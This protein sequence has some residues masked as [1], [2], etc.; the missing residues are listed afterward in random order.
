MSPPRYR[1]YTQRREREPTHVCNAE[2]RQVVPVA[3]LAAHAVAPSRGA[4]THRGRDVRPLLPG[5]GGP[6]RGAPGSGWLVAHTSR[7]V[8]G[9]SFA[10]GCHRVLVRAAGREM[11]A[12][13]DTAL[14]LLVAELV[15]HRL[16]VGVVGLVLGLLAPVDGRPEDDVL[17]DGGRVGRRSGRVLGRVA[18][19]GP[20]L[21]LRHPRVD[22]LAADH[23]AH[24]PGGLDLLPLIVEPVLDYGPCSVLVLN[25]LRRRQLGRDRRRRGRLLEI[26]VVRPVVPAESQLP[27][28]PKRPFFAVLLQCALTSLGSPSCCIVWEM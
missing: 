15:L 2:C 14:D 5:A 28:F 3:V 27:G 25:L 24:P 26:L 7:H 17:A 18:E 10:D 16:R 23:V 22:D 13:A 1:P 21:A 19:L 6:D 4:G 8:S 9:T 12:V 11:L 20:R